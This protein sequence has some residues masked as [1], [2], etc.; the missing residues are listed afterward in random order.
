MKQK[1]FSKL[2]K[3]MQN[4]D[5]SPTRDLLQW[6][7]RTAAEANIIMIKQIAQKAILKR[8]A[9]FC[10]FVPITEIM[11][12]I[13]GIDYGTKRIGLAVTDPLQIFASPLETV[14]NR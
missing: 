6:I 12:R 8:M 13:I 2:P 9:F 10:I 7:S 5:I 4:G 1:Y 11:G 14:K 3:R